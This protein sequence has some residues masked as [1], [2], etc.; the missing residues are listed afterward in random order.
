ML[1]F[2][3]AVVLSTTLS[4]V[5]GVAADLP[6]HCL[7]HQVQ[8]QWEF[9]L[10]PLS[11][12]RPSCGHKHPDAQ[13]AQPAL[14]TLGD[15]GATQASSKLTVNLNSPDRAVSPMDASGTFTMIYDEGFE[16]V[17][18]GKNLLASCGRL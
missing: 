17:V 6:V 12:D 13:D 10:G 11:A 15:G 1:K 9:N 4:Q 7:R 16:V 14:R 8:G 3:A 5:P 18:E 2:A